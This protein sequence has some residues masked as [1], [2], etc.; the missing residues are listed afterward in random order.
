MGAFYLSYRQCRS[1]TMDMSSSWSLL[2]VWYA[3]NIVYMGT[4]R[5]LSWHRWCRTFD[6]IFSL[7][8]K[9]WGWSKK[10]ILIKVKRHAEYVLNE[11]AQHH[12][13]LSNAICRGPNKY[14]SL[15]LRIKASFHA[16]GLLKS[17]K[18]NL[19]L[20]SRVTKLPINRLNWMLLSRV[21]KLPINRFYT[22]LF[23]LSLIS[24]Y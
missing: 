1:T 24:Y 21:T 4:Q 2:T 22:R 19:I 8:Q 23:V 10:V 9:L 14:G 16:Q 7:I 20:L 13:C 5:V 12:G 15:Q 11:I 18:I 6:V 17:R 3:F